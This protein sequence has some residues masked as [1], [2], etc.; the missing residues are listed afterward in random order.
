VKTQAR[1][2]PNI[3][4]PVIVGAAVLATLV[5]GRSLAEGHIQIALAIVLAAS[6]VPL[7]FVDFKI[8]LALWA[9]LLYVAHL[10]SLSVAP[11]AIGMLLVLGW[12]AGGVVAKSRFPVLDEHQRLFTGVILFV[13]WLGL[14]RI[15]TESPGVTQ[16]EV[17]YWAG[18]LALVIIATTI[19][20][21]HGV[22]LI[23][24]AL[25]A[26]AVVSVFIGVAGGSLANAGANNAAAA[27]EGRLTGGGGDPNIQA[28]GFLAA[29]FIG[30]GLLS[31]I[32][33]PVGRVAMVAVIG[34]ITFGL[35]ETQSRG[36]L[37][38]LVVAALCAL[39]LTPRHRARI[40]GLIVLA[41]SVGAVFLA[42]NPE[43]LDRI[44]ASD[45]G[46]GREGIWT[47]AWRV[48]NAHPL[49]GTG[50]NSFEKVEARYVLD[51]GPLTDVRLIAEVP[52]VV[53]NTFLE[54]LA[55][56]GIIG[57]ALFLFV[58]FASLRSAWLAARYFDAI[59]RFAHA[60]LSRGVMTGTIGMLVA[61]FF[62][63]NRT[64]YRM[65][66]LLALGP[67]M[68]TIARRERA[69]ASAPDDAEPVE[70]RRPFGLG[71]APPVPAG[72]A[73]PRIS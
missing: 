15:W 60:N 69:E 62:V 40:F 23:A 8:A 50:L 59:G 24:A 3:P 13:V 31:F 64:D 52:H 28:A 6:Y 37:I 12:L 65:W 57:L 7:V 1:S 48:F 46:S 41:S 66:I 9:G 20:T 49:I 58:V 14:S 42:T 25:V 56:N 30:A 33:R 68:L 43:A 39:I 63:S 54:L 27:A 16:I 17:L 34:F 70:A 36:G 11:S 4:A 21:G 47:V 5:A 18:P 10:P 73:I 53:H 22:R 67:V 61:A 44:T 32:R 72:R 26:G 19:T 35:L 29:I 71:P 38:G 51:P 2:V 55:E 45:G